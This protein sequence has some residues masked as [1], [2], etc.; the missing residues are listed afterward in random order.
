MKVSAGICKFSAGICLYC[1]DL[2][3][4]GG[5]NHVLSTG[6]CEVDARAISMCHSLN[7][8]IQS[9]NNLLVASKP[10]LD[11]LLSDSHRSPKLTEV[12]ITQPIAVGDFRDGGLRNAKDAKRRNAM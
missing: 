1:D 8:T 6:M 11:I 2:W 10:K 5:G 3:L 7:N 12:N 4:I 9:H